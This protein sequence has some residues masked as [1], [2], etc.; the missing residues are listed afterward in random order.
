M[1]NT[2]S[3][4]LTTSFALTSLLFGF[5][6]HLLIKILSSAFGIVARMADTDLVRHG[7]P[8]MA[9]LVLFASMQFNPRVQTW[10][11]EVV[12]EVRKVVFPSGKDVTAMTIVVI[13]FVIL[14]SVIIT[15]F[16]FISAHLMALLVK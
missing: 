8:V 1:E 15:T 14:A 2:N 13:I 3:K 11:E 12:S 4:I 7:V 16:D 9:G 5:T 10:G 6:L